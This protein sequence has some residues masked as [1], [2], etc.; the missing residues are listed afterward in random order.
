MNKKIKIMEQLNKLNFQVNFKI[1]KFSLIKICHNQKS[2][3]IA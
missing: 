3:V 2:V 1:K